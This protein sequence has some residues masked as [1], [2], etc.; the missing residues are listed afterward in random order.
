MNGLPA[1]W[2]PDTWAQ[3]PIALLHSVWEGAV[4]AV[5]LWG[6][7]RG[8]SSRR[9]NLRYCACLAALALAVAGWWVTWAL[10]CFAVS[11]A[12]VAER[13]AIASTVMQS[14]SAIQIPAVSAPVALPKSSPLPWQQWL[15]YLWLLGVAGMAFRTAAL[16]TGAGR[17]RR[18]SSPCANPAVTAFAD[19]IREAMGVGR[20]VALR[21]S[22]SARSPFAMGIVW[23]VVVLPAH[24]LTG[25]P[26]DYLR[27]VL[28]HEFA[29][30]R[31]WDYVVNLLQLI[32]EALLFFNPAVWWISRQVRIERE[33]CCDALA[34]RHTGDATEYA[35]ILAEFAERA[36][37]PLVAAMSGPQP[38]RTL[39]DR[40]RRVLMPHH[41]PMLRMP[42]YTFAAFAVLSLSLLA[43]L[44]GGTFIAVTFVAQAMKP[45][46]RIARMAEVQQ[47]VDERKFDGS[48]T[49][50]VSGSVRTEDGSPLPEP[51]EILL[52][53]AFGG[54]STFYSV[55][56]QG[57]R[58][59]QTVSPGYVAAYCSVEGFA[60]STTEPVLITP[61]DAPP[62]LSLVLR[63]GHT[64]GIRCVDEDGAPIPN[65]RLAWR[66]PIV[67]PTKGQTTTWMKGSEALS[68]AD[69]R[70]RI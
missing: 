8:V 52:A 40:V 55:G 21:V 18:E 58:F 4:I 19:E 35:R 41:Q 29:H 45:E 43:G 39:L 23:P 17:M 42:W 36:T 69:G 7:L 12:P 26:P 9:T 3:L 66:F 31:R 65:A 27:A 13:A 24:V 47:K 6:L 33:A 68:D 46:E 62:E 44:G 14:P 15:T 25:M 11:D 57:G 49:V 48:I 30:I 37:T 64:A 70:V 60:P 16:L 53:S 56:A 5:L 2:G 22:E 32:V 51:L 38:E 10:L 20:R 61:E 67:M 50:T 34:I 59:T 28:A 1:L 63:R 54:R